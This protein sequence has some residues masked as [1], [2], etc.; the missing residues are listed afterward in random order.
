MVFHNLECARYIKILSPIILFMFPDNIIDSM[1]KGLN[2]QF[3][4]MVCNI[5]DLIVTISLLY[6]LLPIYGLTGYL[7][8]IMIS[9]IFNFCISYF[10]LFNATGFKIPLFIRMFYLGFAFLG[11]Y[12]VI[13][14]HSF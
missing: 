14:S 12:E 9:E 7:I 10:Q 11:F 5:F 8:C 3:G 2:K 13:C 6:V 4:V 1:L